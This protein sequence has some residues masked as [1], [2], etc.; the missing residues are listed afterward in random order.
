MND[1][2]SSDELPTKI[3]SFMGEAAHRRNNKWS[4]SS[5][6]RRIVRKCS[7]LTQSKLFVCAHDDPQTQTSEELPTNI[8]SFVGEAAHRG[9]HKWINSSDR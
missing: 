4:N 5:E 7:F 6:S 8:I 2:Q 9:N 3:N 1:P